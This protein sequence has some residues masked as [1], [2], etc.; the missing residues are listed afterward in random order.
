MISITKKELKDERS[1]LVDEIE[2][3]K[4]CKLEDSLGFKYCDYHKNVLKYL[5]TFDIKR[6]IFQ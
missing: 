3:C 2:D 4:Q 1:R 5:R 6:D